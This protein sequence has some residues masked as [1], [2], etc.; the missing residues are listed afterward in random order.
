MAGVVCWSFIAA[1]LPAAALAV[2]SSLRV[3]TRSA[4]FGASIGVLT[5][6]FMTERLGA[7]GAEIG[8]LV[9]FGVM[10]IWQSTYVLRLSQKSRV[11]YSGS[12]PVGF[13]SID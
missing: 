9:G 11:V 2:V 1:V 7:L 4:L 13:S 5:A 12:H 8:L 10:G 6:V 3:A